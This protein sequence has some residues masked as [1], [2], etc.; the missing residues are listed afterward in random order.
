MVSEKTNVTNLSLFVGK[1]VQV[2][3]ESRFEPMQLNLLA[4]QNTS[5]LSTV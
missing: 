1:A 3:F 5:T 2:K 4:V